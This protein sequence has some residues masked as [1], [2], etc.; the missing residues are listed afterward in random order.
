MTFKI[1]S[2]GTDRVVESDSIEAGLLLEITPHVID[3]DEGKSMVELTINAERSSFNFLNTT[4]GIPEK[5]STSLNTQ[6]IIHKG[7]TLVIGGVFESRYSV[8]E[9]GVPCLM[10]IPYFGYLFKTTSAENPK[11]NILFFLSPHVFAFDEI[12]YT[13]PAFKQQVE[14]Y[15]KDLMKIDPDKQER[16]IERYQDL[17]QE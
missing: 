17:P 2:G 11:T 5:T 8:S 9:T 14:E 4:D 7:Q 13:E 16:L 10:G 6:G 1:E 12:P 15:Q 3:G